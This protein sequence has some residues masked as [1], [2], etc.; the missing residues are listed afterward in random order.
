MLGEVRRLTRFASKYEDEFVKAVIG[1]SEQALV[2]E[3]QR[4]QKVLHSLLAR[5]REID[6]VIDYLYE[7]NVIGKLSDERFAKMSSVMRKNRASL[8][9]GS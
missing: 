5:D 3:G 9:N 8:P 6:N 2:A 7:D 4:K 1:H